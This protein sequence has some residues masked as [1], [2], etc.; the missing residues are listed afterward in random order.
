MILLRGNHS[1]QGK[2]RT[3]VEKSPETIDNNDSLF[4]FI[5]F[6]AFGSLSSIEMINP[7]V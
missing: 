3:E 5:L 4:H 2:E 1:S 7:R 6:F